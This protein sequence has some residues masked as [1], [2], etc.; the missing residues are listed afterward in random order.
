M[1]CK[2]SVKKVHNE[3]CL[4]LKPNITK[5]IVLEPMNLSYCGELQ[6]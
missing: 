3:D 2:I 6:L 1:I 4:H 5:L